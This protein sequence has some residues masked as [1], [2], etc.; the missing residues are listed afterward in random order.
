MQGG[1]ELWR[2]QGRRVS[3]TCY[4]PDVRQSLHRDR[5]SRISFVLEG[6]LY[7]ESQLG[8]LHLG[9]G[10]VLLKSRD[11][12]H[13]DVFGP[14]GARLLSLEFLDDDPFEGMDLVWGR[15]RAPN[16]VGL[17]LAII[18]AALA[19]EAAVVECAA[20]DLIAG[21]PRRPARAAAAPS[22]LV[23]L[24][25]ELEAYSLAQVDVAERARTA[26]VHPN[27]ASRLFRRCFG[28]SIT[29]YAQTHAVRRAI[30]LL[31]LPEM[32]LSEVAVAAGFY[33]QSHMNRVFR[34]VGARPPGEHRALMNG[35]LRNG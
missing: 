33:D 2:T 8:A 1:R 13:K 5:H 31:S 4:G 22:W 34:R 19:N 35:M 27:H 20:T 25:S 7:E 11:A 32:R 23:R 16:A 28:L 3:M 30:A 24:R 10:D 18:E 14:A 15:S 21:A 9:P 29:E 17:S 6:G 12:E 26:G